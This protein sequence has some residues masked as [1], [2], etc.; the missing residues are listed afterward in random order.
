[1]LNQ[2]KFIWIVALALLL[3]GCATASRDYENAKQIDTA[4][5][6]QTFLVNHSQSEYADQA[7]K[8]LIERE[9]EDTKHINTIGSFTLF[10]NKYPKSEHA[11]QA[12]QALK[13]LYWIAA[14][15][16]NTVDSYNKFLNKYPDGSGVEEALS[17]IRELRYADARQ[18]RTVAAFETFFAS[19]SEGPDV[20]T[21]RAEFPAIQAIEK[22][23]TLGRA[24]MK[25]APQTYIQMSNFSVT[26]KTTERSDPTTEDL[27][28]LRAMLSEG[29]DPSAVR[30]AGFEPAGEKQLGGGSFHTR[31]G[32]P[33]GS[34]EMKKGA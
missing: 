8:A 18:R 24:I 12:K 34:S 16:D 20:N 3:S 26:G 25:H 7:R 14:E 4:T 33:V 31:L 13:K 32:S 10:L 22:S 9:W 2:I 19:Y 27:S 5:A 23:M 30:V 29:A 1:M 11:S 28:R 21:L 6:Y 17:R 15:Q